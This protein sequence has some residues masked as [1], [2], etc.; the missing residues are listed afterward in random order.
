MSL[1]QTEN[2]HGFVCDCCGETWWPPKLSGASKLWD[3]SQSW[4]LAKLDG[5]RLANVE[6]RTGVKNLEQRCPDCA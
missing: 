1:A 2:G 6:S 5:W 3:T 4:E